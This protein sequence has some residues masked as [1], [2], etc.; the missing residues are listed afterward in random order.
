MLLHPAAPRAVVV[1]LVVDGQRLGIA[2]ALSAEPGERV[3]RAPEPH[4][5]R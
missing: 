3:H 4:A 2:G 1:A 5:P